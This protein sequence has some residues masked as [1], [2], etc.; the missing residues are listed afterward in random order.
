MS[1]GD[2]L[3]S[4]GLGNTYPALWKANLTKVNVKWVR[5]AYYIPKSVKL[6]FDDEKKGVVVSIEVHELCLYEAM[7]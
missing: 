7:F 6:C 1:H 2:R 5:L 4:D 3:D